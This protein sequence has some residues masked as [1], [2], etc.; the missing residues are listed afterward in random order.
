MN[1]NRDGKDNQFEKIKYPYHKK[2]VNLDA[3]NHKLESQTPRGAIDDQSYVAK[4]KY[5][6]PNNNYG[7]EN[8]NGDFKKNAA[9]LTEN[10]DQESVSE[11]NPIYNN[12]DNYIQ[13]NP[14]YNCVKLEDGASKN[15][16]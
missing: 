8:S 1:P 11:L 9:N 14:L 7:Y 10:M 16:L 5:F 4:G 6:N 3:P 13:S 15:Y 2:V 12:M